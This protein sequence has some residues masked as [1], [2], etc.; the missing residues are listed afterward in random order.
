MSDHSFRAQ[1]GIPFNA[2]IPHPIYGNNEGFDV[3]RGTAINPLTG[4]NRSPATYNLDI[5]A[6]YPIRL[7]ENK[8]LRFQFDW[9][10][11]TNTQR[12]IRQDET[13][14]TNSG[15]PGAGFIQFPNPFFGQ[16]TIFQYP[17]S[18]RV[19]IKLQF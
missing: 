15:I 18:L 16:G 9:F 6:A 5:G 10:N 12:A 17:S 8:Q 3:P 11:V 2:L 4:S 14:R 7:G 19:G 1:S 13:L